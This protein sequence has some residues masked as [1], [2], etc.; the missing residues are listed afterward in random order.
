MDQAVMDPITKTQPPLTNEPAQ[1]KTQ[2]RPHALKRLYYWVLS[3]AETPYGTPALFVLAF[4]ESWI[5]PIPPD[6]LQ[7]ALSVS[8]PKRSFYY[9]GISTVASVLGGVF[10]WLIGIWLWGAVQGFF[11]GYVPGFTPEVFAYVKK[12]FADNAFLVIFTAAFT[13]IPDK[14]SNVAAGVCQIPLWAF[15]IALTAGRASRFF[16]VATLIYFFGAKVK[17]LIDKYFELLSIV[18][19]LLVVAGFVAIKFAL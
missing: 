1:G 7:M 18:L 3:W 9:A 17:H 15:V 5:F 8:K 13:P 11:F 6:V 14:V 16:L 12:L 2:R 19:V 4:L 10:G